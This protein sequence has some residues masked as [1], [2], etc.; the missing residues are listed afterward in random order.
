MGQILLW[1]YIVFL[2]VLLVANLIIMRHCKAI[3][4]ESHSHLNEAK[5]YWNLTKE[6]LRR[7]NNQEGI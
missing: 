6:M 4:R 5:A 2:G 7:E 1:A 3:N